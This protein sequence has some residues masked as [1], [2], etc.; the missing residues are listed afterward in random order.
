MQQPS[1]CKICSLCWYFISYRAV[2][3]SPSFRTFS[4]LLFLACSS[5]AGSC[6]SIL[7]FSAFFRKPYPFVILFVDVHFN[8]ILTHFYLSSFGQ[9]P[10]SG[11]CNE[12]FS[13]SCQILEVILFIEPASVWHL[14]KSVA[15]LTTSGQTLQWVLHLLGTVSVAVEI[16][17]L[18]SIIS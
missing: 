1:I 9:Q 10:W 18:P 7:F 14:R 8:Y 4:Q 11:I 17:R 5:L 3:G 13:S 16:R 12:I 6:S 2:Y 15:P